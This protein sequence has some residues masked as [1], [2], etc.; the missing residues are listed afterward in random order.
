M[1]IGTDKEGYADYFSSCYQRNLDFDV[2]PA[3]NEE[4][5]QAILSESHEQAVVTRSELVLYE[6]EEEDGYRLAWN[7][8]TVLDG[9]GYDVIMEDA[10]GEVLVKDDGEMY[11]MPALVS[12]STGDV[13]TGGT[14]LFK[15]DKQTGAA[16]G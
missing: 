10:T 16:Y 3:L 15:N 9:V 7:L 12:N 8:S 5:I 1:I 11:E 6:G 14:G 13:I 4:K 2:T